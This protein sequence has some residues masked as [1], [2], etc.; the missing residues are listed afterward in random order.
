MA[1]APIG[2]PRTGGDPV[3]TTLSAKVADDVPRGVVA[4]AGL[5]GDLLEGTPLDER[6]AERFIT[7]VEG[8]GGLEEGAQ[9]AGIVPDLVPRMS[10]DFREVA[11]PR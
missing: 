3:L 9:A 10:V 2:V 7:A 8:V 5:L 11:G 6:G 4:G 1:V